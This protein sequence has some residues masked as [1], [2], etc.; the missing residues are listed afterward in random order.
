M[1]LGLRTLR[2]LVRDSRDKNSGK[3]S[4]ALLADTLKAKTSEAK[5]PLYSYG[6]VTAKTAVR[7]R[8]KEEYTLFSKNSSFSPS[9]LPTHTERQTA[10]LST[11]KLGLLE[12]TAEKSSPLKN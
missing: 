8:S 5:G 6:T 1:P 9:H 12:H 11:R 3:P 10:G 4:L 7:L 2:G